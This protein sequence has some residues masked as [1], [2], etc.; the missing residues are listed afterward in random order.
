MWLPR[1]RDLAAH[2]PARRGLAF[3][4]VACLLGCAPRPLLER[5]IRARGAP[6]ASLLVRA[7]TEVY[8]GAPG[9][10]Q[11]TR[12][13]AAPDR[14]AWVLTTSGE[15]HHHLFD[16]NTVRTF[17]GSGLVGTDG[18]PG[19]PLRSHAHWAAVTNLDGLTAPG[20]RIDP[21]HDASLPDGATDGLAVTLGDGTHYALAF[22]E[23]ALLVWARGPLD[24][25]PI[26]KDEITARFSDY[27]QI[28]GRTLPFRISYTTGGK[29]LADERVVAACVDLDLPAQAF[30]E[31]G[32]LPACP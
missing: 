23:H 16:G 32:R 1:L 10:W 20:V 13:F 7:E 17:V 25:S 14:Y 2:T 22:D 26:A 9:H 29:L 5:A 8:S 21:W 27:R 15:P 11:W 3:L 31:P 24:L 19:A 12:A 4:F 30:L 6:V 18:T 28:A